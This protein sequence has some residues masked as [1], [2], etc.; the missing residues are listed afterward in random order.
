MPTVK[1][2]RK[3]EKLEEKKLEPL[4]IEQAKLGDYI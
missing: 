2:R 1:N 3:K 4:E